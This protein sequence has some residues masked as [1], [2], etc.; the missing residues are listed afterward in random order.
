MKYLF[1]FLF[2]FQLNASE[3]TEKFPNPTLQQLYGH[4]ASLPVKLCDIGE[5]MPLLKKLAAECPTVTEIGLGLVISTWGILEGL[6]ENPAP[7]RSYIGIDIAIPNADSLNLARRL[8]EAQG[9]SFTFRHGNDLTLDIEPTDLL[10]IDSM[11]TYCHL[12]YELDTFS[13]KVRKYIAMHDTS[14]PWGNRDDAEYC[15]NRSEYPP[16][17]DRG[18]RGLWPAVSDFLRRNH[19]WTLLERHHNCHGFTILQRK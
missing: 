15:G 5:H 18:K 14:E 4:F 2:C 1:I 16:H 11:H 12:S 9:I 8:A 13:P 6:A 17:Y 3:L 10:F 7:T 19:E